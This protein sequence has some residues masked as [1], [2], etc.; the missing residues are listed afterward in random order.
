VTAKYS[1]RVLQ[2]AIFDFDGLILETETPEVRSWEEIFRMYGAAYPESYWRY[3][4]GRGAEQVRERPYHLLVQQVGSSAPPEEEVLR[5][6]G[7][8]LSEM[9]RKLQIMPGVLDRLAE[10]RALKMAIGIA[11]SSKHPWVDG[12]L[13]RL[14]IL[15]AFDHIVCADDVPRAKPFPDLYLECC[16]RLGVEPSRALAFEDSENGCR[17]ARDAGLT[18]VAVP[19]ALTIR[20]DL[21]ADLIVH[22]LADVS[23]LKLTSLQTL[24]HRI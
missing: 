1:H 11:S 18:V 3:T 9:L 8:I 23:I 12:H 16:R 24:P 2:A 20:E 10:A 19:T 13:E 22:S 17:A 21:R 15:D 4:L 5:M 6:R 7:Q 14:G